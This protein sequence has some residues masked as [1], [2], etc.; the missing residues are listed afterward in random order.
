MKDRKTTVINI[1]GFI[2]ILIGIH[3]FLCFHLSVI[4]GF[5]GASL[6]GEDDFFLGLKNFLSLSYLSR[7]SQQNPLI[8][9]ENYLYTL[10]DLLFGIFFILSSIAVFLRKSFGRKSILILSF[11]SII[12]NIFK[13]LRSFP[14]YHLD[15]ASIATALNVALCVMFII[16]FTRC[17][18][19]KIFMTNP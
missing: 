8:F 19:K 13:I 1:F 9:I 2:A 15:A 6:Y 12:T 3:Y 10:F 16:F 4:Y 17:K 11:L 18:I 7:I 14:D 5:G